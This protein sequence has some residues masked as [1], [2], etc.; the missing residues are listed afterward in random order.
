MYT[1]SRYIRNSQPIKIILM[2]LTNIQFRHIGPRL[3]VTYGVLL[4]TILS[5]AGTLVIYQHKAQKDYAKITQTELP[6]FNALNQITVGIIQVQQYLTDI[7][8]TRARDG[9]DDGFIAA[10]KYAQQVRQN[11][12][13]LKKLTDNKLDTNLLLGHFEN[14][15][16]AGKNLAHAYIDHGHEVGNRMMPAFDRMSDSLQN[17]LTPIKNQLSEKLARILERETGILSDSLQY[18]LIFSLF[19]LINL[20]LSTF[21]INKMLKRTHAIRSA[22]NAVAN[23]EEGFKSRIECAGRDEYNEI[24]THFNLFISK[25]SIMVEQ[26][27]SISEQLRDSSENV[28]ASTLKTSNH[29]SAKAAEVEEI[30]HSIDKLLSHSQQIRDIVGTTKQKI[31]IISHTSRCGNE[32]VYAANSDMQ[33]LASKVTQVSNTVTVFNEKSQSINDVIRIIQSIAEQTNLLA[34]NAAIE[35]ARAGEYG[36]GFAVVADE[37]RKLSANTTQAT[38]KIQEIISAI[39]K[40]SNNAVQQV[41]ESS[42][43][44]EQTLIK[45]RAAGSAFDAIT[46]SVNDVEVLTTDVANLTEHQTSLSNTINETIQRINNDVKDLSQLAK[47]NIS[48]NSDLSQYSVMLRLAVSN[49]QNKEFSTPGV[50]DSG[51]ELF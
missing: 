47:R 17:E 8:A 36:R 21:L 32:D 4:L 31:Q 34:L 20:M 25:L 33:N 45:T 46:K 35:A 24:A 2:R 30:A 23:S 49:L 11:I 3:W 27:V 14:Y 42:E 12:S 50:Q 10:E 38:Y 5:F 7:S 37:V 18:T 6:A 26:I 9:L 44:A 28:Q 43:A 39:L 51:T 16:A 48:D 41:Q 19:L 1:T 13:V 29:I 22:M 40:S 15:Y